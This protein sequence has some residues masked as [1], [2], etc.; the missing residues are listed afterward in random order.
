MDRPA[1]ILIIQSYNT[2]KGDNS[3][4]DAMMYSLEKYHYEISLTAFDPEKAKKEYN[5]DAYDYLLSFSKMKKAKNMLSFVWAGICE[6]IWL[7]YSPL[8][9]FFLRRGISMYAPKK[10]AIIIEAYKDSDVVVLP[11]GHFFTSFNSFVNNFSHYYALRFAQLMR[12]KTMVYAQTVGPF[13]NNWIGKLEKKMA[14]RVLEKSNVV[15]LRERDSLKNYSSPNAEVTTEIV[16]VKPIE[17]MNLNLQAYISDK[18]C[19]FIVGVTIHHLYYKHY[20]TKDVYVKLMVDIFNEILNKYDCHILVIPMEDNSKTGGDR[21]II[22]EMMGK[23]NKKGNISMVIDDLTP[24]E[25]A[26]IISLCDIFIGTKT[27]SIVYGLK[28]FTPTLCISYQEKSTE[29]MKLFDMEEFS[30]NMESLNVDDVMR[31]FDNIYSGRKKI[32]QYMQNLY[33]EIADR[34][35]ANNVILNNL[36]NA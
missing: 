1:K 11:G 5:I 16:F 13:R 28:T 23:V 17:R 31:I 4:I 12:K 26:N 15:T 8:V 18:K 32:K 7:A 29:F 9:I 22:Q 3:V 36:L 30:I 25:T 34:A 2:N 27:H 19:D 10:K 14:N 6:F 21:P 20:F 35:E 33:P 24:M